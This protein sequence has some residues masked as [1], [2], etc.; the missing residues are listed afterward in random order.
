[1]MKKLYFLSLIA[2]IACKSS[3][4]SF[5]LGVKAGLNRSSMST[6]LSTATTEPSYGFVAG[7]F[8][9]AGILG[10]YVQPEVQ[11]TQ[12]KSTVSLLNKSG[13]QTLSYMDVPL[14]AGKKLFGLARIYAGPNLQF[15]L[16]A[17]D[18]NQ[19]P[20]FSKSNFNDFAVGGIA[21]AGVDIYK[22]TIDLRY[23]FSISDLGKNIVGLSGNSYNYS[24]R[25]TMFQLILGYKFIDL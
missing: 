23:D 8:A 13:T 1:M 9:R 5:V 12:R 25:A 6:S 4:Q 2:F 10:F 21:G 15:L 14:L 7:A 19:L 22:F 24:T 11:Y 16:D 3:A 20:D 17:K 18:E